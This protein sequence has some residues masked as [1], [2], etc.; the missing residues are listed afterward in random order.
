MLNKRQPRID[1]CGTRRSIL[2]HS[3]KLLFISTLWNCFN[4]MPWTNF[5]AVK[6]KLYA[7]SL[8][9]NKLWLSVY[10]SIN[11]VP[12]FFPLSRVFFLLRVC[13]NFSNCT[14]YST[15]WVQENTEQ[16][17]SKYGYYFRI[18]KFT[19]FFNCTSWNWQF[20]LLTLCD[21]GNYI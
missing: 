3:L 20:S 15:E 21:W 18:Y 6:E 19:F 17:N 1:P 14:Y 11:I 4:K 10:R 8:A 9:S 7:F 13:T 5:I 2:H 12:T 16:E